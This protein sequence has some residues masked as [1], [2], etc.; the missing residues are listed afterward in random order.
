MATAVFDSPFPQALPQPQAAPIWEA[1]WQAWLQKDTKE[2]R[3]ALKVALAPLQSEALDRFLLAVCEVHIEDKEKKIFD[4]ILEM[5][6]F[7]QLCDLTEYKGQ[8][9]QTVLGKLVQS[10]E[11]AQQM[12]PKGEGHTV[13]QKE[14]SKAVSYVRQFVH[15][16]VELFIKA[17]DFSLDD[18]IPTARWE[19]N[20]RLN[21]FYDLIQKP[22]AF[23]R[24]VMSLVAELTPVVWLPYAAAA[25]TIVLAGVG[26]KVYRKWIAGPPA[27]L[28]NGYQNLTQL[29]EEGRLHPVIG[30][31]K[32]IDELA[33]NI[34]EMNVAPVMNFPLLLGRTGVGKT[35]IVKGLAQKI[36]AGTVP[37][38]KG[39]QIY[40][41]HSPS[42]TEMGNMGGMGDGYSSR[43][44]VLRKEIEGKE[45]KVILFFDEIQGIFNRSGSLTMSQL[46]QQLK[47][48]YDEGKVHVIGATTRREYQ[49]TIEKD[50]P[51][52]RRFCLQYID[53][54]D[55]E[56]CMALLK[57]YVS[58]RHPSVKI[59]EDAITEVLK[60]TKA[61]TSYAQ[62]S[63]AQKVLE[64]AAER[65]KRPHLC[66]AERANL[67]TK[68]AILEQEFRTS[69]LPPLDAKR[70]EMLDAA[71]ELRTNIG[72]KL[73]E[74]DKVAR[75][76]Q[77]L[78]AVRALAH[79]C[80]Q[81]ALFLSKELAFHKTEALGKKM[82]FLQLLMQKLGALMQLQEHEVQALGIPTQVDVNLV[83]E[84]FT[85]IKKNKEKASEKDG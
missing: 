16:F 23:L 27:A 30:R 67:E 4:A 49:E 46:D 31:Q 45:D 58:C 74:E 32:E 36:A 69:T 38:L 40:L 35:D 9:V 51:L 39:V 63:K 1:A 26:L 10:A 75:K 77:Q 85:K 11:Q 18:P 2:T 5:L 22:I 7:Q 12:I 82:L 81:K 21:V 56:I 83:T 17:N 76:V 44:Q 19:A 50:E 52:Q 33:G 25:L 64:E 24:W 68:L 8:E 42:L 14:A 62:P 71:K 55:Q 57:N 3:T 41:V 34:G 53:E 43:L 6:S 37:A 48:L 66:S 13:V 47:I 84:V 54:V 72:K 70:K 78:Q 59:S 65:A 73:E 79:G 60:L 61:D 28:S 20:W 80:S 29:A 15:T